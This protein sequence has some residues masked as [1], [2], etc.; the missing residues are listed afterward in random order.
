M[1]DSLE[2]ALA[3]LPHGAGFRF[4][5]RLASLDPGRS[6]EGVY[7]VKDSESFLAAHF[8]GEPI[9]P[10]VLMI[11]AIAQV[12][13]IAARRG[14]SSSPSRLRLAA[15]RQAKILAAPR[16]GDLLHIHATIT[17]T[18]G[19]LVQAEG[20]ITIQA[21]GGGELSLVA[22]AQVTLGLAQ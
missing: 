10:A 22:K 4:V 14:A 18:L 5:D 7:L 12:A 3:A 13:G 1:A 2:Q 11:E 16:P 15:V 17:T 6:A 19:G 21:A 8:P 9:M 20:Q